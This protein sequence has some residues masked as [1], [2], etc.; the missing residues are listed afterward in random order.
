MSKNAADETERPMRTL[1]VDLASAPE[2]TGYAV[3]AW[4]PGGARI[5]AVGVGADDD[6][7]LAR[8]A[9]CDAT[10]IDAPFG[11]PVGFVDFVAEHGHPPQTAA[12]QTPWR[13]AVR[14]RLR[15]RETD[16]VVRDITRR[17]PLSASSDLIA[18][19]MFR[20]LRL[21]A[22]MGVG[23]RS[24]DGRV[25]ETYPAVALARWG[26]PDAGY[27]GRARID[28][29]AAL[30]D[31]MMARCH[32]L[33]HSDAIRSVL[34]SHDDAFDAI[35]AAIIARIASLGHRS[36]EA[37]W[38]DAPDADRRRAARSE[39]WIVLP[40]PDSLDRLGPDRRQAPIG[41]AGH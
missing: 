29:L 30:V 31:A 28:R 16:R 17:W 26:L 18:V 11:W 9:A 40:R 27:K 15:F 20:C 37:G 14:D 22:A 32:W 41:P 3:I 12:P 24:G 7:I 38:V 8:H 23:D 35:V 25:F 5:E 2:K 21:L 36:P 10:G 34:Q 4:T 19:P 33:S 13:P 39:G 6:G 1:G